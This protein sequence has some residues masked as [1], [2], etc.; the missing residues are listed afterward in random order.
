MTTR[1]RLL[2]DGTLGDIRP[3]PAIPV[4]KL[5]YIDVIGGFHY[6]GTALHSHEEGNEVHKHGA[7]NTDLGINSDGTVVIP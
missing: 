6:H 5:G 7:R 4:I 1:T 3:D 2:G